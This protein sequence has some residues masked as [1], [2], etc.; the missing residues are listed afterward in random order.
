M[1]FKVGRLKSKITA[2]LNEAFDLLKDGNVTKFVEFRKFDLSGVVGI[3]NADLMEFS[4]DK[5]EIKLDFSEFTLSSEFIS[6]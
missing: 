1:G 6:S 3:V 2:N 4:E 5:V